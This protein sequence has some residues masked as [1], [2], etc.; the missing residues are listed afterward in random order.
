MNDS[1]DIENFKIEEHK[2]LDNLVEAAIK[3]E[4]INIYLKKFGW[5]LTPFFYQDQYDRIKS[6]KDNDFGTFE[7]IANVLK[8]TLF[9]S[10]ILAIYMEAFYKKLPYIKDFSFLI[11][12]GIILY[13][14]S[15]YPGAINCLIPIIEGVIRSYLKIKG[16]DATTYKDLISS[17]RIMHED[18]REANKKKYKDRG[19]T[20]LDYNPLLEKL[21]VYLTKWFSFFEDFISNGLYL[22][23][24]SRKTY[25]YLNRH[26]ILHGLT[27][28]HY[29]SFTNATKVY[30][31]LQYLSWIF[32]EMTN[33]FSIV[34]DIQD[35]D[36]NTRHFIYQ[37]IKNYSWDKLNELKYQLYKTHTTFDFEKFYN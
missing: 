2:Y 30:V 22:N 36:F 33:G 9:D 20:E 17:L 7:N 12:H 21:G 6:F 4:E 25:D 24:K 26:S 34:P 31:S 3:C 15:D 18:I 13:L 23:T 37:E 35:G 16:I 28:S 32:I 8:E 19:L 27:N 29:Y 11:D 14:Q 10:R 1:L 5:Y